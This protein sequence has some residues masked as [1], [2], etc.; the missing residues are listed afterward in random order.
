MRHQIS[1]FPKAGPDRVSSAGLRGGETQ[2]VR[3]GSGF[4]LHERGPWIPP[5]RAGRGIGRDGEEKDSDGEQ[6]SCPACLTTCLS[7]SV[8]LG[9]LVKV[10]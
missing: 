8:A 3:T 5:T 9:D 1:S 2:A 10:L 4:C 6:P 7:L